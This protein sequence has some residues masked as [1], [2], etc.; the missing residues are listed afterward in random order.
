MFLKYKCGNMSNSLSLLNWQ[1]KEGW[2]F[3]AIGGPF[4]LFPNSQ[5]VK[6]ARTCFHISSIYLINYTIDTKEVVFM[7]EEVVTSKKEH[8]QAPRT[9][10]L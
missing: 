4:N 5:K 1:A 8:C 3:G 7:R 9:L 6:S 10:Q 2:V